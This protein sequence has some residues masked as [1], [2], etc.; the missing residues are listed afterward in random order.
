MDEKPFCGDTLDI[1]VQVTLPR[2]AGKRGFTISRLK[3]VAA[4]MTTGLIRSYGMV[5]IPK[6]D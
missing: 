2:I 6:A 3:L 4:S 5:N 1:V